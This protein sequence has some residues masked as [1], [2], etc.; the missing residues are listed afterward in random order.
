MNPT[1]S[2]RFGEYTSDVH[3]VSSIESSRF[4]A[5][6]G[7][8]LVFDRNTVRIPAVNG[9]PLAGVPAIDGGPSIERVILHLLRHESLVH[10]VRNP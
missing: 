3:F 2:F 8:V 7:V 4:S 1:L 6:S 5:D 9:T 10:T